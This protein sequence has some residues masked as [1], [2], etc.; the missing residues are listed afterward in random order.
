LT[1]DERIWLRQVIQRIAALL[2]LG[3]ALDALYQEA[4]AGAFTTTELDIAR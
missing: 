2:A 3:P 1:D 4:A